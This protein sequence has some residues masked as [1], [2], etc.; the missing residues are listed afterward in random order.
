MIQYSQQIDSPFGALVIAVDEPGRVVRIDFGDRDRRPTA[1]RGAAAAVH[2]PERTAPVRAQL[3]DYFAGRRQHFELDLAPRG[4]DFQQA[5][6]RHL[7]TIPYGKT[8]TYAAI[9]AAL[10]RPNSARAVGRA[11]GSNPIS[12]VIPCHRVVGSDGSLTGFAGG[13]DFK[14]GLLALERG[15]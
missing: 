8:H 3:A 9:A 6:W 10:G 15:A 14:A 2:D 1:R 13:L 7:R 12:I 11:V 4:T 5:V